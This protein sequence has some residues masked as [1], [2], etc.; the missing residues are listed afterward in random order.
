MT[1]VYAQPKNYVDVKLYNEHITCFNNLQN[2]F[3]KSK[4]TI[5]AINTKIIEWE[6]YINVGTISLIG[7]FITIIGGLLGSE[8][9][10]IN[11]LRK[12]KENEINVLLNSLRQTFNS[13]KQTYGDMINEY[14][15]NFAK[16]TYLSSN[17]SIRLHFGKQL[18]RNIIFNPKILNIPRY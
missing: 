2:D 1:I 14:T 10:R 4:T 12:N 3:N 18:I 5:N 9:F 7:V 15:D 8:V 6:K 11:T 13:D 16:L 17:P